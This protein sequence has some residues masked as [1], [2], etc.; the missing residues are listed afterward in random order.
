MCAVGA[1]IQVMLGFLR[2]GAVMMSNLTGFVAV[3][4]VIMMFGVAGAIDA[5]GVEPTA[6]KDHTVAVPIK[7]DVAVKSVSG[8]LE[9]VRRFCLPVMIGVVSGAVIITVFGRSAWFAIAML[10]VF[11]CIFLGGSEFIQKFTEGV[12]DPAGTRHSRVIASRL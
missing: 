7:G 1:W 4:S 6:E 12:G 9:T 5:C 8:V 11:S 3:L 2:A 10:I